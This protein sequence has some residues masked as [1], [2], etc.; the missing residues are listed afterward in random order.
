M[1]AIRAIRLKDVDLLRYQISEG[2]GVAAQRYTVLHDTTSTT[3]IRRNFRQGE[4]TLSLFSQQAI[5]P[6][7]VLAPV[8]T[9]GIAEPVESCQPYT[10]TVP[11]TEGVG[12]RS[13]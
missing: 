5:V 11:M 4:L 2:D 12:A 10:A 3:T 9:I 6:E 1:T 13:V 7:Q 8:A